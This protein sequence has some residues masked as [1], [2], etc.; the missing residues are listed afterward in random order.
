MNDNNQVSLERP[1]YALRYVLIA[2]DNIEE[3][4]NYQNDQQ[5]K[6]P[7]MYLNRSDC[8]AAVSGFLDIFIF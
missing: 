3:Q 2:V 1:V 7:A 4:Q 8:T 6:Q 5:S